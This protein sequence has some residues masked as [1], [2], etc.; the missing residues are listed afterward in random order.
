[1]ALGV[2]ILVALWVV[3]QQWIMPALGWTQDQWHYGDNRI[4]QMDA[5]VG[6]GGESHF[7]AEYYQGSILV[8]EIPLAHPD[9]FHVYTL[10]GLIGGTGTP[11]I[12]L[13]VLD[14]NHDGKPDLLVQVEGTSVQRVLFNTGSAFA[15]GEG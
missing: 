7:L 11:L 13:T 6:H 3:I 2:L 14:I 15:E 4:T 8:I 12:T 1:M 10:T 5:N 9:H